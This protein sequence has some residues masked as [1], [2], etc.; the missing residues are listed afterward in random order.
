[1]THTQYVEKA[2]F[3]KLRDISVTYTLPSEWARRVGW[4]RPRS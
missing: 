1:M 3:V 2:D 4:K